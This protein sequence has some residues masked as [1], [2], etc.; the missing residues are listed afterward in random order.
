MCVVFT[1]QHSFSFSI[2][3]FSLYII[4]SNTNTI[5]YNNIY[6]Y[7]FLH[8]SLIY[9][10]IILIFPNLCIKKIYVF[11]Q[12][13]TPTHTPLCDVYFLPPSCVCLSLL[14]PL[15]L[16]SSLITCVC[17]YVYIYTICMCAQV[18]VIIVCLWE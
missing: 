6:Y 12:P 15:F 18:C 17:V 3:L 10:Y 16:C 14:S 11:N 8:C 5:L 13:N 9:I 2:V 4:R 1:H 7:Y